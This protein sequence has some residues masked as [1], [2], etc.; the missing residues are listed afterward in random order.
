MEETTKV[1]VQV[2][3]GVLQCKASAKPAKEIHDQILQP[4][5]AKKWALEIKFNSLQLTLNKG[6][7]F[8]CP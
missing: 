7:S 8:I 5:D 1:S 3:T 6:P 4:V 2:K